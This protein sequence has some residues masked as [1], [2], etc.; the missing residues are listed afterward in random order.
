[1]AAAIDHRGKL[2]SVVQSA[3]AP[4]RRSGRAGHR[5][6]PRHRRVVVNYASNPPRPTYEASSR[7]SARATTAPWPSRWTC[8]TWTPCASGPR[9]AA[10]HRGGLR[11]DPESPVPQARRHDHRVSGSTVGSF[12]DQPYRRLFCRSP[13]R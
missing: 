10:A 11:E 1:M 7:S 12:A 5:R 3:A 6:L 8:R 13:A 9:R 2:V 4:A